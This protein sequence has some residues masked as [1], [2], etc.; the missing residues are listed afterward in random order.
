MKPWPLAAGLAV[1]LLPA[2]QA[3]S[4]WILGTEADPEIIDAAGNVEYSPLYAGSRDHDYLDILKAW[5]AH[6][7]VADNLTLTLQVQDAAM[8][9]KP[10]PEYPAYCSFAGEVWAEEELRGQLSF[11]ASFYASLAGPS[12]TEHA[13]A[14]RP[15]RDGAFAADPV[16]LRHEF[17][18]TFREPGHYFWSADRATIANFGDEL[19]TMSAYCGETYQPGGVPTIYTTYSNHNSASSSAVYSFR[20]LRR[21]VGPDG[22]PD[23]LDSLNSQLP[24]VQTSGSAA[25]DE[26][27]PAL[28]VALVAVVLA[29]AAVAWRRRGQAQR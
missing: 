28:G 13:V 17:Q 22:R 16:P 14:W 26:A 24:P 15:H 18:A 12:Y 4:G 2:A 27:S 25:P 20:D 3:Q 11:S 7:P 1:V 9:E 19:R 29:G 8:L 23:D 5:L 6:D 10:N 21:V